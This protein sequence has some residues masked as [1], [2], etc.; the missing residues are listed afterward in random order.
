MHGR[1]RHSESQ[2][3][4]ERLNRKVEEKIGMWCQVNKTNKWATGYMFVRAAINSTYH[5]A[6]KMA[7]IE[8]VLGLKQVRGIRSL[9]I[10]KDLLEKIST[11]KQL[12]KALNVPEDSNI[13]DLAINESGEIFVPTSS[14]EIPG[15]PDSDNH[16][17]DF[18]DPPQNFRANNATHSPIPVPTQNYHC[19]SGISFKNVVPTVLNYEVRVN[20]FE[21]H[22]GEAG[23]YDLAFEC[24]TGKRNFEEII[25]DAVQESCAD[26]VI[27][28]VSNV[29]DFVYYKK[30]LEPVFNP[31]LPSSPYP[32]GTHPKQF[33]NEGSGN[34][35]LLASIL[36]RKHINGNPFTSNEPFSLPVAENVYNR[37]VVAIFAASNPACMILFIKNAILPFH[38]DTST[39]FEYSDGSPQLWRLRYG[40]VLM[41]MCNPGVVGFCECFMLAMA[42]CTNTFLKCFKV[43]GD[44]C[45]RD[46]YD[47]T[48]GSREKENSSDSIYLKH[49]G[50]HFT[51]FLP[52]LPPPAAENAPS[53][54]STVGNLDNYWSQARKDLAEIC[55]R[56]IV[57]QGRVMEARANAANGAKK[58]FKLGQI[59][60][61]NIPPSD[62][63]KLTPPTLTLMVVGRVDIIKEGD[64][65]IYY[66]LANRDGV[67]KSNYLAQDLNAVDLVSP[68]AVGLA[69]TLELFRERGK[70]K[71]KSVRELSGNISMGGKQ[72]YV[73]CSCTGICQSCSCKKAGVLCNSR[74]HPS[75]IKCQNH[76][77]CTQTANAS[78]ES[79][80][81]NLPEHR[82]HVGKKRKVSM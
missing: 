46:F 42:L 35:W 4:V 62:K 74:C 23:K 29:Q 17:A 56:N 44:G 53:D 41:K 52:P 43:S 15:F 61:L 78:E 48:Y 59:V 39:V 12:M 66:T 82:K 58:V 6:T 37:L 19:P 9:P 65:K 64:T 20:T 70:L 21:R 24:L 16:A 75:N 49:I 76:A 79:T 47:T 33:Q 31:E 51:T 11:E 77:D 32:L 2:G 1:P 5:Y 60:Q 27:E 50:Y 67:L 3:M 45:T 68:A 7:P 22:W 63:G 28:S 26:H 8:V 30:V 80:S 18:P 25:M 71:V 38:N 36:A 54:F 55:H 57:A 34:C 73:S 10:S 72:G 14:A 40:E 69:G 81:T 13:E